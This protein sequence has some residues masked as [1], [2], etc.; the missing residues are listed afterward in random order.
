MILR[1]LLF[2]LIACCL[3]PMRLDAQISPPPTETVQQLDPAAATKAW[4]ATVSPDKREKS[5][6][7]F[8]GGYWLLLWNYLATALF[9]IFLLASRWS[10][11]LRDF[12]ERTTSFKTFQIAIY[13][14]GYV[15]LAA[16]MTFPLTA[17][18]SFFREHHYGFATQTFGPW[19]GEQLIGLV[20]TRVPSTVAL[21]GLS[22]VFRRAS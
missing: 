18:Q 21:T 11:R 15:L 1:S 7:Y 12:A 2:A 19:F 13:T 5:D 16:V 20:V 10:A 22:W 8:E 3:L 6:A 14:V 9:S 4:L 17:Y